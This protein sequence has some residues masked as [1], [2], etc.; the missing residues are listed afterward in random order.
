MRD[1]RNEVT[2]SFRG[3]RVVTYATVVLP[4]IQQA[5]G[6]Q[7]HGKKMLAQAA[8]VSP[9]TAENWLAGNN[10]PD[11]ESLLN[12]FARCDGLFDAV[13][14]AIEEIKQCQQ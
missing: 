2:R 9:R 5:Y 8:N 12:L 3:A 10:A 6:Q 14:K 13:A 7:R 11:G 1:A 4:Y